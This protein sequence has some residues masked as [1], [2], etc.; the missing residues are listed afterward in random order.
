[1]LKAGPLPMRRLLKIAGQIAE[2]KAH[3]SGVIHRDLK[4]ENVM[5]T[6]RWTREDRR[7]RL[8]KLA[9]AHDESVTRSRGTLPGVVMGTVGY[10]SPN[11]R[12]VGP[13]ITGLISSR[14]D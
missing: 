14:S 12:A 3:A 5:I 8:A 1:V 7:L 10:M 4:P 2:G 9:A 6:G 11:R 13:S